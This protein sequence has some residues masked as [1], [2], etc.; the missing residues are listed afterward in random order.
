MNVG[1]EYGLI[2]EP[3]GMVERFFS[4]D[5]LLW[6]QAA[7]AVIAAAGVLILAIIVQTIFF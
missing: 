5:S 3:R 7:I 6:T 1:N 2:E 4:G